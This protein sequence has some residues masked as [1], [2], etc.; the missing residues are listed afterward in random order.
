MTRNDVHGAAVREP[1]GD[2]TALLQL[3][4]AVS[5]GSSLGREC[6]DESTSACCARQHDDLSVSMGK[7]S[8]SPLGSR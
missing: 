7:L 4:K 8:R 3:R 6:V 1:E 5:H 2:D